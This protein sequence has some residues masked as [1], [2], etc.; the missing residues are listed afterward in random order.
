MVLFIKLLKRENLNILKWRV[1]MLDIKN[2]HELDILLYLK[3][4]E[5]TTQRTI[6]KDLG[7]ALGAINKS[8]KVL[9]E[10]NYLDH[11]L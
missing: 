8:I 9:K 1:L 3:D 6:S 5:T 2:S 4:K 11:I 10:N 7:R